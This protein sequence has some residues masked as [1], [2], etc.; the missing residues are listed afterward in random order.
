MLLIVLISILIPGVL[1]LSLNNPDID[2]TVLNYSRLFSVVM[3]IV[4][5]CFLFFQ[6]KSHKDW[7]ENQNKEEDSTIEEEEVPKLSVWG[8]IFL[9]FAVT[10][11]VSFLAEFLVGSIENVTVS[12]GISETFVGII[13]LPIVGNAT[14]HVKAVSVAMKDKMDLSIGVAIGSS[15]QISLLVIPLLVILGWI[16]G[17]VHSSKE[18][19]KIMI[20]SARTIS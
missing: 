17:K 7:F 2:E 19:M 4:Y 20:L 3:L 1:T 15:I 14:E 13:L 5:G 6:L 9:L 12:L 16:F 11:L 8:A 10:S 18:A